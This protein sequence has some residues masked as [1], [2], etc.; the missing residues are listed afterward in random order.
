MHGEALKHWIP[1][2]LIEENNELL[3]RWMYI[4]NKKFTDPFFDQTINRCKVLPENANFFKPTSAL[5]MLPEWAADVDSINPSAFIFH[6]SRC[7][8][9]LLSQIL[10]LDDTNIALSE[11]P[12][13]DKMLRLPFERQNM[14]VVQSDTYFLEALKFYG[15]PK[16]TNESQLFI[17]LDSWHLLFYERIRKLYPNIT[18]VIL[19]RSPAD[20]IRSQQRSRGMQSVPGLIEKE[21]FG[22][23]EQ[24]ITTDLDVYMS[25]VLEKYFASILNIIRSDTNFLLVNYDEGMVPITERLLNRIGRNPG[26][27]FWQKTKARM[28]FDGK[29]PSF[30]FKN[31]ESAV[32][33]LDYLQECIRLYNEVEKERISLSIVEN[34]LQ[35]EA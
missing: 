19:Y 21:V 10:A 18:F 32:N 27:D 5:G 7:G 29:H 3:C 20:I 25:R 14:D 1:V 30:F 13:L 31:E 23:T 2:K 16:D 15:Q 26:P 4:S 6:V 33:E 22:F 24:E 28:E 9:T 34:K 12:F 17:K 35:Q 8:S 11:V